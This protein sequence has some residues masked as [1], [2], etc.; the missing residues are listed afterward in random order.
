MSDPL[1][2][3]V[4]SNDAISREDLAG[5]LGP[6]MSF[7]EQ[8]E[9]V[10][11]ARFHTFKSSDQVLAILLAAKGLQLLG[12]REEAMLQPVEISSSGGIA[13]GTVR[14]VVRELEN[15]RLVE[16]RNGQYFVPLSKLALACE[17]LSGIGADDG[18]K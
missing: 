15:D 8:G 2:Q 13:R 9:I 6:L 14:R 3:L 16:S 11:K 4:R 7:T 12:L 10:P 1:A 17:K 5:A 18:Q